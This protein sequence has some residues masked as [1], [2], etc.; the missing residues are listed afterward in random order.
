MQHH[1]SLAN[2]FG[3]WLQLTW[4]AWK[5][6]IHR[7]KQRCCIEKPGAAVDDDD[8]AVVEEAV[9]EV[10]APPLQQQP[11]LGQPEVQPE[12]Q[13]L[14]NRRRRRKRSCEETRL[15]VAL[16]RRAREQSATFLRQQEQSRKTRALVVKTMDPPRPSTRYAWLEKKQNATSAALTTFPRFRAF[17]VASNTWQ[18][19]L[20]F[21]SASVLCVE[22]YLSQP[23]IFEPPV[24]TDP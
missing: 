9:V 14:R 17:E 4:H 20:T 13:P 10:D 21:Y 7:K 12:E 1:H 2:A 5:K 19:I 16:L 8:A 18:Q 22:F 11:L 24:A 23:R 6:Y 3:G 15:A